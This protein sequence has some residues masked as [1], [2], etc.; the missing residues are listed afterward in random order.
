MFS[1]FRFGIPTVYGEIGGPQ[2]RGPAPLTPPPTVAN[3]PPANNVVAEP[4]PP[5][6][7]GP[8][9]NNYANDVN[10][11]DNNDGG[12]VRN[13]RLFLSLY[14][15][16]SPLTY[17]LDL[18]FTNTPHSFELEAVDC[19]YC[20][21]LVP[22]SL[23]DCGCSLSQ[24]TMTSIRPWRSL[25]WPWVLWLTVVGAKDTFTKSTKR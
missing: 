5:I 1:S 25:Q 11:V 4:N 18:F 24:P 23:Y 3:S 17:I 20:I 19:F 22:L 14:P 2:V 6:Q 16:M 13:G 8:P 9:V 21:F 15:F 7:H 10:N 12:N